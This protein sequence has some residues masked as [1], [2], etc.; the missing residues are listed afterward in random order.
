MTVAKAS[1]GLF[2]LPFLIIELLKE[3]SNFIDGENIKI[4]FSMQVIF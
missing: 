4:F 3:R 2:P 1:Q